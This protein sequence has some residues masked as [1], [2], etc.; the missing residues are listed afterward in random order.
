MIDTSDV[1]LKEERE[2]LCRWKK[3]KKAENCKKKKEAAAA[4]ASTAPSSS[5]STQMKCISIKNYPLNFL[6]KCEETEGGELVD[7]CGGGSEIE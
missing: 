4:G 1:G 7:K 2:R 5:K 6:S 3:E